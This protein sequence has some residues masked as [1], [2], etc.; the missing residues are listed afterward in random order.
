MERFLA[1]K[2]RLLDVIITDRNRQS[3]AYIRN[4][5]KPKGTTHFYDIW[6]IAKGK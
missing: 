4:N 5:M 3:A 2:G 1:T 6:N